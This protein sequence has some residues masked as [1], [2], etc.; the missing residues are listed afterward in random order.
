MDKTESLEIR[1]PEDISSAKLELKIW[2]AHNIEELKQTRE[3]TITEKESYQF[4]LDQYGEKGNDI[5]SIYRDKNNSKCLAILMTED[6]TINWKRKNNCIR[7]QG[8]I[9]RF[10]GHCCRH[11]DG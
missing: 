10:I 11:Y 8:R 6:E 7:K 2:I 4:I 1:L 5:L 9:W 3:L